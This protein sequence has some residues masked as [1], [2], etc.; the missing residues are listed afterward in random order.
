LIE[1]AENAG[2]SKSERVAKQIYQ[3]AR[4]AHGGMNAKD[5]ETFLGESH[6]LLESIL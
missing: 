2:P 5:L 6:S 1:G 4:L 3:L